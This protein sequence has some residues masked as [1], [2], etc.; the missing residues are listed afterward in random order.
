MKSHYDVLGVLSTAPIEVV[1]AAY[2][3]LINIYH[4]DKF[5]GETSYAHEKTLE[6]NEAYG[7]L[8]N[9]KKRDQYDIE[10]NNV[11][12][13]NPFHKDNESP[14]E[15]NIY[16]NSAWQKATEYIDG[17]E[18]VVDKL[19]ALS[20]TLAFSFKAYL[21][22]SKRF[23]EADQVANLMQ[24]EFLSEYFGEDPKVNKYAMRL[25]LANR[26]DIAQELNRAVKIIGSSL[27]AEELILKI[28]LK[29]ADK[30]DLKAILKDY[31]N[32]LNVEVMK[33]WDHS[34][35]SKTR[36]EN[37]YGRSFFANPR[38]IL[39]QYYSQF[40]DYNPSYKPANYS[41]VYS[42]ILET[43]KKGDNNL[44]LKFI[45]TLAVFLFFIMLM[46][47]ADN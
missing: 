36:I 38:D 20:P 39:A 21:L 4:P 7:V 25:L 34:Y 23:K 17:L 2:K 26:R 24:H 18:K 6:L 10:L 11:E 1:K 33:L 32:P 9:K 8:S 31:S 37:K 45:I 5:D 35:V 14:D 44:N 41:D 29:F 19:T 22:D 12:D 13:A 28:D 47:S 15:A 46:I 43:P 16:V 3:T 40:R 27:L 42:P 30:V